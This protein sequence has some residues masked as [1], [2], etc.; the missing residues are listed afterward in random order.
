MRAHRPRRL[1]SYLRLDGA[2]ARVLAIVVALAL[3]NAQRASATPRTSAARRAPEPMVRIAGH[4]AR[5]LRRAEKLPRGDSGSTADPMTLTIV[6]QRSDQAGFERYLHDVYDPQSS[7]FRRFLTPVEIADRFGPSHERY[8]EVSRYLREQGFDVVDGS[9]NRLTLAV[10]G[11]RAQVERTFDVHIADYRV[12]D[13]TFYANDAEPA[14][15]EHLAS[16]VQAVVGMSGFAK[17]HTAVDFF[18]VLVATMKVTAFFI[19]GSLLGIFLNFA[20]EAAIKRLN[21]AA[22][23]AA[24]D[25]PPGPSV[26]DDVAS[27]RSWAGVDG[28]GQTIGLVEFDAFQQSDVG[29]YLNLIGDPAS[30]LSHLSQVHVNGGATAGASQN[31]VLLDIDTVLTLAPGA[32]VVVYDAPF[33]GAGGSF[34]PVLNRMINDGVTI[35]SNSWTYCEDQTTQ[36]DVDSI[37]MLFQTAAASGISV[38]NAAGDSGTTCL[39]GSPNTVGVPAD[40]PN[41]TAVGGTS[42][43]LGPGLTYGSETWWDGL[44]AVPTTGQ[45]GYGTSTF[46]SRPPYQSSLNAGAQRSVPDVSVNADPAH[47]FVICQASAGGCPTGLTNGGTSGGA[48]T[49]AAFAALLNQAQGQN[50]GF[51][52]PLLYPF[53]N[54]NGFH[55]AASMGSDFAHV[56][57]GSPNLP[58]LHQ[59]LCGQT[60]GAPDAATSEVTALLPGTLLV[61]GAR[62]I[63]A[64]GATAGGVLVK[65]MDA[66]GI[67]VSGKTITLAANAGSHAT[68]T[69]PSGI[70]NVANGAFTFMVKDGTIEDVTFTATDTSDGLPLTQQ[71]TIS[72]VAP[73]A[74][75]GGI[76]AVPST[77]AADGTSASTITVTLHDKNGNGAVG[78]TVTLSQGAGRSLI[79]GPSPATTDA[80]GQVTF[81]A[82][83]TFTETVTYSA[84]DVT[85]GN[86]PLPVTTQVSFTNGSASICPVSQPVPIAGWALT[87]PVTGF[88][89]ANNCVGVSGTAWDPAGNLWA[90]NYP[91]G[92]LYKFP[93]AGGAA[94]AGTLVGTVPNAIP[95]TGQPSC[96][97][98]LAF[99]KDGQHLYLARQFCGAGG[100]V[101]EISTEDASIVRSL[102]TADAIHCATGIATDPVSGDLFVTSP[103]QPGNDLFRI[104]N[105]ESG[106]PQLSVYASPGRA[107]GLNFTPDGTIWTEAYPVA[108]GHLLVKISGT[109]SASPGT[110]TQL[111]TDAPP[112]AGGILPVV[113]PG[114][115]G[116]PPFLLVSNGTTGGAAG[117]VSKVDL[118]QTPPVV[119]Q[120]AAGGT[121][122]IFLNGG[123]D[124]CAYVS[125][126][127]RIDRITAADGT[128]NFA[129]SIAA[130]TLTL[131]PATIAPNPAQG[132]SQA[133]TATLA[134]AAAGTPLSFQILGANAQFHVVRTDA[135]GQATFSYSGL[136]Q[137]ADRVSASTMDATP[138][139]SNEVRVTW[140][141]GKHTTFLTLNPSPTAGKIN[142]PA[143]V[144]ASLTDFT[145]DPP[146]AV[147]NTEVDFALGG[148]QCSGM[149]DADGLAS[150]QLTPT[151]GGFDTLSATFAG[152]VALLPAT[153]S[154]GF[155][156]VTTALGH[157]MSYAVKPTKGSAKFFKLGPVTL[158]D[159]DFGTGTYDVVK[160]TA[161]AAPANKNQEGFTDEATHLE[162]YVI[163]ASKGGAKFAK[164]SDVHV[165]N[166]CSDLFLTATKPVSLLVPTAKDLNA[167]VSPPD[168]GS[169][170]VDHFVCYAA[171]V[172]KK[173]TDGTAVAGFP[174][175]VQADV[176]DQFETRRYDLK[177]VALVCNP[178]AK[179]GAP[180]LLAGPSKG[181]SFPL[182]PADVRNP[183]S[184][185]VCYNAKIA[186]KQIAQ[187]G[188]GAATPG[189]K[190]TAITPAQLPPVAHAGVHVANQLGTGQLDTKKPTLLCIPTALVP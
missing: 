147:A 170:N 153:A 55:D 19:L 98:G 25:N 62:G 59:L 1:P 46:F 22:G 87:S 16:S 27:C 137:G 176:A 53:A 135:N 109:N 101:V 118:T 168:E 163:K 89:L 10:R 4:M 180:T 63:P 71:A 124:G 187:S 65:L 18:Y 161:L 159:G 154:T 179:S 72:F 68:I 14:L 86:L 37:D 166:Q 11:S 67:P 48:P 3:L 36:A 146:V 52:N 140:G 33:V 51:L 8:D 83:D 105:P 183:G 6:L 75:T 61:D 17:P 82:T 112:A 9:A 80:N 95:P 74:T 171:K 49:W 175:G 185:L 158:A 42:L 79:A 90:M 107:I 152:T 7:S 103:C 136:A 148:A 99:S 28:T 190:G 76:G 143:T 66:N 93:A 102:T 44:N 150:C 114:D 174:K 88:A 38:F 26:A 94:N 69:P 5:A 100:D 123:P 141:A 108:G 85:D 151:T 115:T 54:T 131:T 178:V 138:L 162:A 58:I 177:S 43:T 111:S 167:P 133:F 73:P 127:D 78:K 184:H 35:I 142:E 165:A 81:T 132:T 106:S 47:G 21:E 60:I 50:L 182:T 39:D 117:S 84:T 145:E 15:P 104:A 91:T 181:A 186:K 189:D 31:E 20:F 13:K 34:Q 164:R 64:D 134:G 110:V 12:G 40:S 32:N 139:T 188:C 56:G 23:K 41:A 2:P 121:G 169:H 24:G 130:P 160:P 125:N 77:V 149:T 120:I 70:T 129:T 116:N 57:L 113:N 96:P 156:V 126:G 173:K 119:T 172:Q 45:G 155:D 128:C 122:M 29:D 97:H 144:I 92:K 157:F 30:Q